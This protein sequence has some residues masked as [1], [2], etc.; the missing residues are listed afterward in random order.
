MAAGGA[1]G[2]RERYGEC[3]VETRV[4]DRWGGGGRRGRGL[5]L[6]GGRIEARKFPELAE[7]LQTAFHG[8]R[9]R[10]AMES[11]KRRLGPSLG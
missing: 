5:R 4:G 6:A 2:G 10:A 3:G 1:Q 11:C 8:A 9:S 7:R